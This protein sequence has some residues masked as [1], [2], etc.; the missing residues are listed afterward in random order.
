MP[1][2][3]NAPEAGSDTTSA[4]ELVHACCCDPDVGLC[5]EDLSGSS[6]A[7]DEDDIECV[8]CVD[9]VEAE[10]PCGPDCPVGS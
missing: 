8:V 4:S 5:G 2:L 7:A 9:L 6:W 3:V 10:W 1:L